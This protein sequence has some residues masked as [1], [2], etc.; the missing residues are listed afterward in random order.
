ML[1][2]IKAG[3]ALKKSSPQVDNKQTEEK[4]EE[5]KMPPSTGNARDDMLAAIKAGVSLKKNAN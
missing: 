4:K 5:V 2:Q 1:R 3:V